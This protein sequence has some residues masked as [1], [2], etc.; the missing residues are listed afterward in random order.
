MC[1][2]LKGSQ[3]IGSSEV[4]HRTPSC[5]TTVAS[6]HLSRIASD[7]FSAFYVCQERTLQYLVSGNS[8]AHQEM[9]AF[10]TEDA[11]LPGNPQPGESCRHREEDASAG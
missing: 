8:K 2:R 7:F 9:V 11:P 10:W 3:Q 1:E 6:S 5:K 4:S